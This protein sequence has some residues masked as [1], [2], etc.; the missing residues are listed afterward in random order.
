MLHLLI[1]LSVF[2]PE[3]DNLILGLDGSGHPDL[4]DF[5][6]ATWGPSGDLSTGE[7]FREKLQ[8][9]FAQL[10]DSVPRQVAVLLSLVFWTEEESPSP[11][12][13]NSAKL[14]SA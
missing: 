6:L 9:P 8:L 5:R 13:Q 11:I 4:Q 7:A 14:P 3:R 12:Y 2:L 10:I 1:D